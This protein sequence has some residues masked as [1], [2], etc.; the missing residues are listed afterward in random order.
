MSDLQLTFTPDGLGHA[1]YS[2][3]IDL[4][5]LGR[6]QIARATL[7]E[8]C[9]RRQTWQVKDATGFSLF[10]SP[11]RQCCLEWEQRYLSAQEDQKHDH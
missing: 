9:N 10:H 2:E 3:L 7:I 1:L 5:V 8:Y 6:L 11:S 4:S